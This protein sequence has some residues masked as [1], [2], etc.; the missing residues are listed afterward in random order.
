ME[1]FKNKQKKSARVV[2][3]LSRMR[4]YASGWLRVGGMSLY[5][6]WKITTWQRIFSCGLSYVHTIPLWL[7]LASLEHRLF[8]RE[9]VLPFHACMVRYGSSSFSLFESSSATWIALSMS[10]GMN[11]SSFRRAWTLR[12]RHACMH[13]SNANG[14]HSLQKKKFCSECLLLE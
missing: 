10:V 11:P 14:S 7:R 5:S 3:Q 12:A 1:L 6:I 8:W 9:Q 2:H 13:D 4:V